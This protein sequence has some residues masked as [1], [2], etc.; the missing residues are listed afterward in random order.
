MNTPNNKP[1]REILSILHRYKYG[2]TALQ[3]GKTMRQNEGVAETEQILALFTPEPCED[4]GIDEQIG[5]DVERLCE[6]ACNNPAIGMFAH[7]DNKELNYPKLVTDL[8]IF[9]TSKLHQATEEAQVDVLTRVDGHNRWYP[10]GREPITVYDRIDELKAQL[11]A[12]QNNK[13][14]ED[15]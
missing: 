6:R 14:A 2:K 15:E 4:I 7:L 1:G 10:E 5:Q 9:F 3:A 8:S 12:H 13:E 11:T